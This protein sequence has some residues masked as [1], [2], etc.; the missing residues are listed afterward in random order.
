MTSI[1]TRVT[2]TR[3]IGPQRPPGLADLATLELATESKTLLDLAAAESLG[4]AVWR[5]RKLAEAHGLLALAQIAPRLVLRHLDMR[6]DLVVLIELRDTPVACMRSGASEVHIE[7]GALLAIEYPEAIIAAPIPG[8]RP[9][10]VLA[11]HEVYHAN[12]AYGIRVPPLCLGASVPRG[13]PLR[14]IV[15]A[16]YAALTLQAITLDVL[17]PAGVLNGEAARW[18]Q[19]NEKQH[20]PLHNLYPIRQ[21][22]GDTSRPME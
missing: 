22:R 20:R 19:A 8:T 17:D 7:R 5:R 10:R 6:T 18:W 15:L 11:P 13:L 2:D 14:E 4:S 21:V 1:D 9:V 12:V 3:A 16:S